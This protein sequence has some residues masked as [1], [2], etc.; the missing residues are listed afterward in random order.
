MVKPYRTILDALCLIFGIIGS[1]IL[2]YAVIFIDTASVHTFYAIGSALMLVTALRFK[3][4]F[5]IALETIL[6]SGHGASILQINPLVAV[7]LPILLSIQFIIYILL[8]GLLTTIFPII[9][10]IGIACISVGFIV[11][12]Q[13]IF[14]IGGLSI[15]CYGYYLSLNGKPVALLW[16]V[17]NAIFTINALIY[18]LR[19]IPW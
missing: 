8:S 15:A 5:F 7:S 18:L 13:L 3:L 11:N 4:N 12:N 9:G 2:V 6:L 10:T 19:G 16:A 1:A 17:T 14:F